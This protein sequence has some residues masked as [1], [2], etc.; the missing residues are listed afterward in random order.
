MKNN[1]LQSFLLV[2]FWLLLI[3]TMAPF[4]FAA[5]S[6]VDPETGMEFVWVSGGSFQMGQGELEKGDLVKAM[7]EDKFEKYCECELPCHHVSVDGFWMGKFEV[8]N[9]QYRYFKLVHNS[10]SYEGHLLNGDNQPVVRVS[11]NDAIAFAEWLSESSCR[12][13]RLPSEA[14]WEYACRA[15]TTTVCF[16]G[17]DSS[18]ACGYANV[19]DK[20]AQ[21]EWANWTVHDCHDGVE[22]TAPVGSFQANAFGLYD[23]LGNV[24]EWCSDWFG[25]NYY[26]VS[27]ECNPRGLSSGMYRV[28]RGSCW[29]SPPRY[30]RSASRNKRLPDSHGYALGF[31]LV[32]PGP[33]ETSLLKSVEK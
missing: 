10:G 15:G 31:R 9:A 4:T 1:V 25:E 7:G 32:S 17:N 5:Q 22:V 6:F 24:W 21:K 33:K 18:S 3:A 13:F 16:W 2:F 28:A 23:M 26:R 27:P 19:G 8:T 20:T 14:E 29:D 11:C 30:V 12:K